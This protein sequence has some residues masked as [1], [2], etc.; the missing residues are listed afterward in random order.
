MGSSA[1][2]TQANYP[3]LSTPRTEVPGFGISV[4][5]ARSKLLQQVIHRIVTWHQVAIGIMYTIG[6]V[7]MW[8]GYA[9][10]AGITL[11]AAS[12]FAAWGLYRLWRLDSPP[13]SLTLPPGH[14]Y[15]G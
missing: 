1:Y 14:T 13:P 4:E 3:R 8:F 6:F 10:V 15:R 9:D 7:N 11:L 12:G 5:E 2:V